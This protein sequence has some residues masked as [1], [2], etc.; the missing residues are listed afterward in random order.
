[1]KIEFKRLTEVPKSDI[2]ALMNNPLVKRYMPLS[3][4]TFNERD[5]DE[6][7]ALKEQLWAEHGYG[8]W[9]FLIDGEFVGWGGLQP[10]NGEPDL[11]LVLHPRHW[12]K[13]QV[14]YQ[15]IIK[16]AF[17]EMGFESI[18]AL[19]PPIRKRTKG[20]LRLGFKLD[21]ELVIEG[22]R[23]IRYRLEKSTGKIP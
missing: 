19:L 8:P 20:L 13:G 14:L 18:T 1:M 22:E 9:A 23:F 2:I 17:G 21:G 10:E 12:G 7:I 11:G 15:Q 4:E 5:F 16:R 3:G 6:F